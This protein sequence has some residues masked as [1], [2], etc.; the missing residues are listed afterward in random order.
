MRIQASLR[1]AALATLPFIAVP[2]HAQRMDYDLLSQAMGELVTKS[3]TGKPQRQSETPAST[4]IITHDQILR[5]P[6]KDVPGLLNTYAGIDVSR[7]TAG[8]SDV[9]VR[10]GVQTYNPRL[11]V[12]VNGRQV[13]LDHYGMTDWNLL[14]IQL[15]EI[16][17]IE[18]VRGPVGALFGFNAASG[19]VNIITID[20]LASRK[21]F[22]TVE[23]GNHGYGRIAGAVSMPVTSTIGIR[24]SGGHMRENER[25]VP[26]DQIQPARADDVIRDDVSATV[27]ADLG[28]QT[29]VSVTGGYASN[30]QLELLVTQISSEQ[31]YK[32]GNIGVHVDRDTSWGS[33]TAQVYNN[34][35]DARYGIGSNDPGRAPIAALQT[36][37]LSA[38]TF[39]AQTS[40]LVRLGGTNTARI[41][42]EYRHNALD[43]D[44]TFSRTTDYSVVS[45][46]AMLDLQLA[47]PLSMTVAGRVDTLS[48]GQSGTIAALNANSASDFDRSFT[49][50]SFNGALVY[51]LG[52]RQTL[53]LNGGRAVQ[54]P[55]LVVFGMNIPVTFVGAPLPVLVAGDPGIKPVQV[56]S[57]E[58]AYD[59][60]ISDALEIKTT[61]FFTR[62]NDAIAYPGD[63]PVLELRD[64]SDPF[65]VARVAN[66]GNFRTYGVEVSARGAIRDHVTW[67]ANYSFT[68]TDEALAGMV[69]AIEYSFLPREATARHKANVVIDYSGDRWSGS[70]IG[71]YTSATRQL[72]TRPDTFLDLF[73]IAAALALDAKIGVRL[74][75]TVSA[76]VAGENLTHASGAAGSPLPAD[77]RLRTGIGVS[78]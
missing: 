28:S 50:V 55:S 35:L 61:A 71:R 66:I 3:V 2:A 24:V 38:R 19:V 10:G 30:R 40:A 78:F 57:A 29:Q 34:W 33:I 62:T 45:A 7:W 20:L 51:R 53:R 48:L 70:V 4:I 16:Q 22:A 77:T 49:T 47:D 17:Q 46:N 74:S 73:D 56:W 64:A 42:A 76:W 6:A 68:H 11:L 25:K 37:D 31:R 39:V 26:A 44:V 60:R 18:L 23:T 36:F 8:Q 52:A 21:I 15:E 1:I 13:Y 32:T 58:L 63:S 65:L 67:R 69:P 9:A 12:L 59:Y 5:S 43:S 27:D 41:G 75:R 72:G 14:G 54:A